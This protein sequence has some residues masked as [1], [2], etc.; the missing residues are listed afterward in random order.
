MPSLGDLLRE[1]RTERHWT[2]DEV[3]Q[4]TRIRREFLEALESGNYDELPSDVQIQG[5]LRTYGVL[6]ELDPAE[7]LS[8]YRKDRGEPELVSIARLTS[9]PRARS[10]ALPGFGFIALASIVIAACVI[11]VYYGWLNPAAPTPTPT[12]SIATPTDILPTETPMPTLRIVMRTP[13]ATT[14]S[15]TPAAFTGVEAVLQLTAPCWVRVIADGV[16]IF[17][18]TLATGATRT[19]TATTDLSVRMGNAG[20]VR[21]ILN[22]ED[23]GVQ[24]N[25][26]QVVTR[27]W[28][29]EP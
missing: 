12:I 3:A 9:P 24:G 11:W 27:V 25:P 8:L 10:C 20:G 4:Q 17:E 19:F 15:A 29:A 18:G 26:G 2:L 7:L 22:G 16:Q 5:F 13:T 28:E 21:I 6:L 23:Q 1:R 14:V